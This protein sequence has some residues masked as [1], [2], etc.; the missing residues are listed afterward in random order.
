MSAGLQ[1]L[2]ETMREHPAF[3][4]LLKA[5]DLPPMKPFRPGQAT[6]IQTSEWI[7]RSGRQ[8]Q[9]DRWIGVLTNYV[10]REST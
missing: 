7:Y 1:N 8:A 2:L 10:P 5:V 6:D 4:E 9:H 3:P